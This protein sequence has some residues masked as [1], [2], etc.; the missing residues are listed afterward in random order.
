MKW[1]ITETSILRGPNWS[2]PFHLLIDAS[3]TTLGVV[4]GQNYLTPYVIY[5]MSKNLTLTELNY[6]VT[7][8]E[9][10]VVVHAFNKFRHYIIGYETFI[11]T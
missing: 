5:N 10:L 6:T 9:I 11:H 4:L 7:K 3:N 8:N 2:L 1:E